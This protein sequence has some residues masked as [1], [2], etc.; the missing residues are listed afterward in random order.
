[1]TKRELN[2]MREQS[3]AE[4]D[5]NLKEKK[6][7]L[8]NLRFQLATGQLENSSAIRRCKR[9]I[10]QVKTVIRQRELSQA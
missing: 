4:L 9:E 2:D 6:S 1:M 8:F 10:A 5:T 7:E 3:M